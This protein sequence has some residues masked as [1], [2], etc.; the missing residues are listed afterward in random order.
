MR[1]PKSL[2]RLFVFLTAAAV[3]IFPIS[4]RK[5][6]ASDIELGKVDQ[7]KLRSY[8]DYFGRFF[9]DPEPLFED[10]GFGKKL[11]EE[12]AEIYF[13][14]KDPSH[15]P[16]PAKVI[17]EMNWNRARLYLYFANAGLAGAAEEVPNAFRAAAKK[18]A[19]KGEESV[20]FI[21]G[22]LKQGGEPKEPEYHAEAQRALAHYRKR[23]LKEGLGMWLAQKSYEE[24]KPAK[25]Y[26]WLKEQLR[27]NPENEDAENLKFV[28][29]ALKDKW[30]YLPQLV[31]YETDGAGNRVPVPVR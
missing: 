24:G 12:A 27:S 19:S 15:W 30:G 18:D 31:R 5:A 4:A 16:A 7:Y 8:A 25:A 2:T 14:M 11:K 22:W 9:S 10:P 6:C 17:P 26:H 1:P 29:E 28:L 21:L 23:A 13:W 3:L 20:F